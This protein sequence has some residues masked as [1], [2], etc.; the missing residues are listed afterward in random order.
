[1]IKKLIDKI[2]EQGLKLP[3]IIGLFSIFVFYF[4][5]S[6]WS[7]Q[8][9]VGNVEIYVLS[10]V[11]FFSVVA[12]SAIFFALIEDKFRV[13]ITAKMS[14]IAAFL[15]ILWGGWFLVRCYYNELDKYA[16]PAKY[17]R[18]II[19]GWIYILLL[20]CVSVIV[21]LS[22][23][24]VSEEVVL[25][26]NLLGIVVAF[27]QGWFLYTP[28]PFADDLGGIGH[29]DAYTNSIINAMSYTPFEMYSNSIYGH[30]G[31]VYMI[32][33]KILHK[34]GFTYWEGI[35]LVIAIFGF[36]TFLCEC[37]ALGQIIKNSVVY[38]MAVLANAIVSFQIYSNQYF[39][40]MPHRY[41]FQA[42]VI[43]GCIFAYRRRD[44]RRV[45]SLMWVICSISMLW[46]IE[47]GLVVTV[48]WM[49]AAIY[50]EAEC[51]CK[52]RILTIVKNTIFAVIAFLGGYAVINAYNL[53]VGGNMISISTYI[54][55]IGSQAYPIDM[56]ELVLMTP[57]NGYFLVISVMFGIIG[58]YFMNALYLRMYE[59]QYITFLLAVMGVGVFTYY[60]NRAVTT[61]ATIVTFAFVMLLGH[62][63]DRFVPG[64]TVGRE[65]TDKIINISRSIT[66]LAKIRNAVGVLCL[67]IL[68]GLAMASVATVGA[69][70]RNKINTTWN[71]ESLN[72]FISEAKEVIPTDTVAFGEYTAQLYAVMD[73]KT[74][75]YI[76]DFED[77]GT[78]RAGTIMNQEA[79]DKLTQQ[80]AENK[81][82]HI[83]VNASDL[84]NTP[85]AGYLPKGEYISVSHL[86]YDDEIAFDLYERV[87]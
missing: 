2:D 46:N 58:L 7:E 70:L 23:R 62:L 11:I 53:I 34:A 65:S 42:I 29:I 26:R 77:L 56:L 72:G 12:L 45:R 51:D 49:L 59:S 18:H 68:T 5:G 85:N 74:G 60:M 31:L 69:T 47:T 32:P 86:E 87:H 81:Y 15:L 37:W 80:I 67:I 33:V 41:L 22:V 20:T 3:I 52:Y 71:M 13:H 16:F 75:I 63:S 43:C 10:A 79:I 84:V 73:R 54:Y 83:L 27:I 38:F 50:I 78:S 21:L 25:S 57:D 39:Q 40:M 6:S 76:A 82:E 17:F 48:V 36:I 66:D 1:M 30:H 35:T 9:T 4:K 24:T 28:N 14:R 19:P 8:G 44:S 61:N 55:P 64:I